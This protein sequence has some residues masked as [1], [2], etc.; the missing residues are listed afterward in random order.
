MR[1]PEESAAW[2][3]LIIVITDTFLVMI[4]EFLYFT[5]GPRANRAV[6]QVIV[7]VLG[8]MLL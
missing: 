5:E 6:I 3:S 4:N 1:S 8:F 7:T 2:A